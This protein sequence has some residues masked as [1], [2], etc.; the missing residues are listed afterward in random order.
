MP[1]SPRTA[2]CWSRS[3][4]LFPDSFTHGGIGGAIRRCV[5]LHLAG[6]EE[7]LSLHTQLRFCGYSALQGSD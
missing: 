5:N 3:D 7:P 1:P 2:V 6:G 4:S